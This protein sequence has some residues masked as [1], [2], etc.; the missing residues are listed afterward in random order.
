MQRVV[1]NM[2]DELMAVYRY[3]LAI[4]NK[5]T[6]EY[7]LKLIV[8]DLNKH[9]PEMMAKIKNTRQSVER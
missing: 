4:I 6:S 7:L 1:C 8:D 5:R 3:H 2:P 9:Q